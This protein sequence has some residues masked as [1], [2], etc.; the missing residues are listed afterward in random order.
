MRS[1]SSR[2]SGS[3]SSVE[4][5]RLGPSPPRAQRSNSSGPRRCRKQHRALH[6]SMEPL[7]QVQKLGLRPVQ[8]LDE[9]DEYSLGDALL[10]ERNPGFVQ[11]VARCKRV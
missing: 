1:E 4:A 7:E 3:S 9:D 5:A 8:I 2:E 10:D 11:A 6:V